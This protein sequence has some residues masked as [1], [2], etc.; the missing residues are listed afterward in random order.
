MRR[1]ADLCAARDVVEL[2]RV[3]DAEAGRADRRLARGGAPELHRRWVA[4]RLPA[5][6]ALDAVVPGAPD[7]DRHGVAG[8][9]GL[10]G[11]A[12]L[13][14]VGQLELDRAAVGVDRLGVAADGVAVEVGVVLEVTAVGEAA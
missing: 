5:G 10:Q 12:G 13:G 1:P 11:D 2:A 6:R 4:G 3:G 14:V 9:H 7:P 8:H